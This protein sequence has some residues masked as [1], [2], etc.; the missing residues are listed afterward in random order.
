MAGAGNIQDESRASSGARN[1]EVLKGQND[2]DMSI[3]QEPT[4]G[5]T[6]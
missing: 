2:G 4:E 6:K 3:A 5:A 1:K